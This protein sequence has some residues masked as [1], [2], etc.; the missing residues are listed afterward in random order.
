MRVGGKYGAFSSDSPL[1]PLKRST[2]IKVRA[3]SV[4]EQARFFVRFK[5]GA[6]GFH[7]GC[8]QIG[9][10]YLIESDQIT[11][12]FSER[13]EVDCSGMYPGVNEVEQAFFVAMQ[14]FEWYA[15]ESGQLRIRYAGGELLFRRAA[16]KEDLFPSNRKT[17][18]PAEKPCGFTSW[19]GRVDP[20]S[21]DGARLLLGRPVSGVPLP[22]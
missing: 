16:S 5:K 6:L 21:G 15:I 20:T 17:A 18:R 19:S 4:P 10:Y 22:P 14:S 7:G 11:I 3:P 13:T 9:G 8:N 12:T 2:A 1:L